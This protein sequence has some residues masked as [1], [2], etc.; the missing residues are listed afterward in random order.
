[1]WTSAG[2]Q[3]PVGGAFQGG[4]NW[5]PGGKEKAKGSLV[6]RIGREKGKRK[7][8]LGQGTFFPNS[9]SWPNL[10]LL[11]GGKGFLNLGT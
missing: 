10:T 2:I 8:A 9:P 3:P 1:M 4:P 11:K 6:T 7:R 5:E